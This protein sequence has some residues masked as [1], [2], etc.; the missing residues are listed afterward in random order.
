MLNCQHHVMWVTE[1]QGGLHQCILCSQ[2]VS[3]KDVTPR[4]EDLPEDFVRRWDRW[5]A[6]R[7]TPAAAAPAAAAPGA[8]SP[9]PPAAPL[10]AA[11]PASAAAA[12]RVPPPRPGAPLPPQD[13]ATHA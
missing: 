6:T 12:P 9:P 11:V 10:R 8:P 2:V 7:E 4:M 13:P 5:E 3:K 1:V